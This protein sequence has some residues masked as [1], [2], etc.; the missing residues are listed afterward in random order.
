MWKNFLNISSSG[1]VALALIRLPDGYQHHI[2]TDAVY[3]LPRD[4]Q[5][6]FF[7][8]EALQ[9]GSVRR[10]HQCSDAAVLQAEFQI[11]HLAQPPAIRQIDHFFL[12]QLRKGQAP[13]APSMETGTEKQG[14]LR[15]S[16]DSVC[17]VRRRIDEKNAP[18]KLFLRNGFSLLPVRS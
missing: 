4:D 9:K 12:F 16:D 3:I 6:A 5:A 8:P 11:H 10:Y 13:S 15:G 14:I 17:R 7:A 1:P 2:V 18:Q